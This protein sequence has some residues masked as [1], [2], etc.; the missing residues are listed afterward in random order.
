MGKDAIELLTSLGYAIELYFGDSGRALISKGFL[1]EAR[2]IA[3]KVIVDL[4]QVSD[5]RP[6]VGLEP[7]AILT[8]RDEFTRFGLDPDKVE[9]IKGRTFLLEEFL[10]MEREEGRVS[11]DQFTDE[12]SIVHVHGH[13][14][15]KAMS[16][17]QNTVDVLGLPRNFEVHYIPSGCCGMAGSFGYEK[18]HYEVSMDV[19]NLVLF[20][21]IRAQESNVIFAANGT[22]C[23]HQILDGTG[24]SAK[25]PVSILKEALL[26]D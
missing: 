12:A 19:G 14:H 15:Q 16:E 20:P 9:R 13:C 25:H 1:K 18:E 6:I 22:S 24:Q 10:A 11:S 17:P 8:L 5:N 3:L 23:R 4:D 21:H 7:S 26:I 2:S